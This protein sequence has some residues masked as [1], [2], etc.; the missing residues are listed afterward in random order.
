MRHVAVGCGS[1]HVKRSS[2]Q[3]ERRPHKVV[4]A[5]I[6][7][8]SANCSRR[9]ERVQVRHVYA[10]Q[11]ENS[12]PAQAAAIAAGGRQ[13]SGSAAEAKV[14]LNE[15]QSVISSSATQAVVGTMQ[16]RQTSSGRLVRNLSAAHA[17][18][19]KVRPARAHASAS[20][21]QCQV[22]LK[23]QNLPPREPG[24]HAAP[25]VV[26]RHQGE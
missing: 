19:A 11:I 18:G 3:R 6:T 25:V 17:G 9:V 22:Q 5:K 24:P 20:A 21:W 23:R 14:L 15:W 4:C 7:A 10:V 26:G 16:D 8:P 13:K 12:C 1:L 2:H